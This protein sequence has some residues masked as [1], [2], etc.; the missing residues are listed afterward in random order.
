MS[1]IDDRFLILV[2]ALALDGLV[3]DPAAVWQRVPHPVTLIGKAVDGLDTWLNAERAGL[4]SRRSA[5][6][7][8]VAALV[9]GALVVGWIAAA[10]LT[11]LPLTV[12]LEAAVV[13]IFIAGRSLWEHVGEVAAGLREHGLAG[14]REAVA[15]IVG[16]DPESLDEAGVARAAIES[17]AESFCDAVVAPALWYILLGLPG[18]IAYKAVNTADSMIGHRTPRHAEFGAAAARLDD[19]LNWVPA[20]MAGF[21]IAGAARVIGEDSDT[22]VAAMRADAD[23]HRSVNA[24]WPEAAMAGALGLALAGP[25]RYGDALVDDAWMNRA[26]RREAGAADIDRALRLYL[27]ACLLHGGAYGAIAILT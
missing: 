19:A 26:G 5:G 16:R 3:G 18:L 2:V 22:A 9:V 11:A 12:V 17:T 14:G 15:R 24:G 23:R 20:R 10:I 4:G 1:P 21:L 6:V 7:L 25:R 8:A 13:S 27:W